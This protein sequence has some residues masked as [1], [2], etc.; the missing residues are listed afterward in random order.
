MYF[1]AIIIFI[2]SIAMLLGANVTN[3]VLEVD[4][5][6]ELVFIEEVFVAK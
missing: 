5:D 6:S 1:E 2:V 3:H 4:M